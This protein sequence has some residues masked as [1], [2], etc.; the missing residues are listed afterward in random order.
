MIETIEQTKKKTVTVRSALP[1]SLQALDRLSSNYWWSWSP[2]G[3]SCFRDID[4]A[5]WEECEHNPRLLLA[6]V[7]EYRLAEIATDPIYLGRLQK[8]ITG[9]D[10]YMAERE[11]LAR[12]WSTPWATMAG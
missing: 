7:S 5:V 4:T 2:D 6:R 8:L 12:S 3:P 10:R 1:S 9:F 11:N